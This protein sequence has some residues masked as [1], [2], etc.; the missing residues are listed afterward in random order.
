MTSWGKDKRQPQT[1]KAYIISLRLFY[2]FVIARD[3]DI[4]M[5]GE[6]LT[7]EDIRLI[8]SALTRLGTWPKAFS[9]A[10]NLRK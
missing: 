7:T 9:D 4:R 6:T 5:L 1:L 10:A 2:R 3:E 8:N